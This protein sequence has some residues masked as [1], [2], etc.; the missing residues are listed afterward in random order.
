[1]AYT[2]APTVNTRCGLSLS[3]KELRAVVLCRVL[4]MW[5][6]LSGNRISNQNL[7]ALMA[8]L[9]YIYEALVTGV[10][11]TKRCGPETYTPSGMC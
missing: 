10:P 9:T 7:A 11:I 4:V 2:Q 5:M 8:V 1:M 3:Q 6:A